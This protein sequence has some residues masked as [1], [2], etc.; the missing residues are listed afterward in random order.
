MC[1]PQEAIAW[2]SEHFNRLEILLAH[3]E[4]VMFNAGQLI[5]AEL[6]AVRLAR[7]EMQI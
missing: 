7:A 2:T 4:N 1:R 6:K 3:S 5:S